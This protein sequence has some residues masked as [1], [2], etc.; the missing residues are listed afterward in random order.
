MSY[1][2]STVEND[3]DNLP[4]L[5]LNLGEETSETVM[6][7]TQLFCDRST[8]HSKHHVQLNLK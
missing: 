3:Y 2:Q 7:G 6:E 8:T 5:S 4:I 1:A